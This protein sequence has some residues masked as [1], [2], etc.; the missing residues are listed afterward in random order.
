MDLLTRQPRQDRRAWPAR[1]RHRQEHAGAF[2]RSDRRAP[3]RRSQRPGRG[4]LNLAYHGARAQDQ[5]FNITLERDFDQAIGLIDV[6]PQ[7]ITR[8]FLNL[9]GNGFYAANKRQREAAAADYRPVLK[10][11]TRGLGDTV[12]V[13]IRDNGIGVPAEIRD[14]LFQPFFTTKPTGEGTG[15][16]YR[17]ATTSSPSSMAAAS[18]STAGW[19]SSPSSPSACPAAGRHAL[20]MP[21]PAGSPRRG[22]GDVAHGRGRDLKFQESPPHTN[23]RP[24]AGPQFGESSRP[25]AL[26]CLAAIAGRTPLGFQWSRALA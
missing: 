5:S 22:A 12:E 17:S 26:G 15:S 13:R 1:R 11:A 10:V 19:G 14:K 4:A 18:R 23:T 3:Q 20:V 9:C 2:A 8:V 16:G 6:A 25:P 21:R 7:E 24:G